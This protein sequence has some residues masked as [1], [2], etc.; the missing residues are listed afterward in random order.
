VPI[1]LLGGMDKDSMNKALS[2]GAKGIAG[3]RGV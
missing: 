2:I 1:Y 3:I